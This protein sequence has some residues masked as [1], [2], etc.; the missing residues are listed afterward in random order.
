MNLTNIQ[1]SG[2]YLLRGVNSKFDNYGKQY[3]SR[4]ELRMRAK[5]GLGILA[6]YRSYLHYLLA[7]A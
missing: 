4:S 5:L 7:M 1:R 3:E 6:S 2:E